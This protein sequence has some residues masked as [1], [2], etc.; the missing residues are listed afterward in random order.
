MR[1]VVKS[2]LRSLAGDE[3][4]YV[5]IMTAFVFVVV[6]L[7]GVALA[8]VGINEFT[9]SARTKLMDQ[10]YGVSE[11][12]IN[13]AAVQMKLDPT[14][15]SDTPDG[16]HCYGESGDTPLWT[17]TETFAG[18]SYTTEVWQSEMNTVGIGERNNPTYKVVK[19]TGTITKGSRTA[20]RTI[21]ARIIFGIPSDEY[22]ASFDY[23]IY[24][25]F[26]EE[27]GHGT[28]PDVDYW[29]GKWTY[30]GY[31][32]YQGHAPKGAIYSKG[33]INIPT[34][35][36]SSVNIYGNIVAT[37]NIT[38]RNAWNIFNGDNSGVAL[39]KG[40]VVA[41]LDGSGTATVQTQAST[42]WL[43]ETLKVQAD[44]AAGKGN[45]CAADDV[46]VTSNATIGFNNPLVLDGIKAGR[47]V[48]ISGTAN[49]SADLQIGNITSV[50]KTYVRSRW[51]T[52]G[53]ITIGNITAGQ[54]PDGYGVDLGTSWASSINVGNIISRGRVNANATLAGITMGTVTA[55]N[56]TSGTYGG[57]GVYFR[58]SWLSGCSAGNLTST[59]KIDLSATVASSIETGSLTAGTDNAG[60]SGG[61][62]VVVWGNSFS[63]V[64]TNGGSI[65]SRGAVSI[66]MPAIATWSIN[67]GNVWCG[68]NVDLNAGEFWFADNS[69]TC[70]TMQAEGWIDMKSGD[71][72]NT[73][74][75]TSESSVTAQCNDNINMG[76]I[77]AN[78]NIW[79]E[80]D[81]WIGDLLNNRV[82][83][84]GMYAR[85]NVHWEGVANPGDG[86]S[87][88]NISGGCWGNDVWVQRNDLLDITDTDLRDISPIPGY[89]S[90][91]IR[92]HTNIH[93]D[94][95]GDLFW[96]TDVRMYDY[97]NPAAYGRSFTDDVEKENWINGDPGLPG[98]YSVATPANPA[99]PATPTVNL[100]AEADLD[101]EVNILEPNWSY[102]LGAATDDDIVN[103]DPDAPHVIR[104]RHAFEAAGTG[105]DWGSGDDGEI[106]F[107]WNASVTDSPY[108]SNETV[109]AQNGEDIVL[110]LN[111]NMEGSSF[112]GTV[113]TKGSIYIDNSQLDWF[114]DEEQELNLVAGVDIVKRSGG[115][116][117]WES[118]DCHFHF[119]ANRNIDLRD[120]VFALGSDKTFYGSFT[121]GNRVYYN[122]NTLVE[123]T[124][125]RWS[126]WSLDPVAWVEPFKVQSWKE[127]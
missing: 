123:R 14:L 85:G 45:V 113:V 99:K 69:I 34:Q 97:M 30:D 95:A 91:S 101:A 2:G 15:T 127:M 46:N 70:G 49:I 52:V 25:G 78:G 4:G 3:S 31:T 124:T 71:E 19:S 64:D 94:G 39:K 125:F 16:T 58:V 102:F 80:S 117:L 68:S 22:D 43:C 111:W 5:M 61:T 37:D 57:T 76:T 53:G 110:D 109:Y 21:L 38:L 65:T 40:N 77:S 44:G 62:G 11:A 79:V 87:N 88:S 81:W 83:V 126:R 115:L 56:D 108:S 23:C 106:L 119:W 104:D 6:A 18:G 50:R 73:S 48:N 36:A 28:W 20:E 75:V 63:G 112:K 1:P 60:G 74:W 84:G 51:F 47:D 59:G 33:T 27:G 98:P 86:G 7:I 67:L 82:R 103:P 29:V 35:L 105:G 24:N 116:A 120:L 100:F 10:S 12:G 54:H 55:G 114:V 122:S 17:S 92:S 90:Q 42:M 26:N 121:A 41:G 8:I 9:L 32:A 93:V 107:K 96:G 118:Q 89:G 13:R 72:I 66:S